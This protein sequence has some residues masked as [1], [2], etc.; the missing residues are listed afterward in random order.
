[1][2]KVSVIIP[3]DNQFVYTVNFVRSILSNTEGVEY[4]VIIADDCST[5]MTER[6]CDYLPGIRLVRTDGNQGFIRNC[7]NAA[8]VANGKYLV[9]LNNDTLVKEEWLSSLVGTMESD[10]SIG[11]AGS[12]LIYPDGRLQEAGCIVWG[13]GTI[14]NYGRGMNPHLPEFNYFKDTDYVSGASFIIS[15]GLWER[16]GGFDEHYLPAYCEDADLS[17]RVRRE[18]LRTVYQ[19]RSEVIHFEGIS[20]GKSTESGLKAYQ[21][22]NMKK[23]YDR[24]KEELD[25]RPPQGVDVF[26]ARDRSFGRTTVVFVDEHTVPYD[27]DA[28]S[29]S[30]GQYM[31]LLSRKG[32]CVKLIPDDFVYDERYARYYEGMGIEV[33]YGSDYRNGWKRWF[34]D[35]R[36][37]IDHVILSR[38][39]IA[40]KYIVFIKKLGIH[41][42]Y[43][44]CDLHYLRL[45]REASVTGSRYL[46]SESERMRR[47]ETRCMQRSDA[48]ITLSSYELPIIEGMV[49]GKGCLVPIYGFDMG[50]RKVRNVVG[51]DLM[52]VGNFLHTPNADAVDWFMTEI[53]PIVKRR[54]PD[55]RMF[56][57]GANPGDGQTGYVSEDVI[58]TGRVSDE[59]LEH[60][61]SSC[62]VCVIPLRYGAGVK[63]KLL[64]AMYNGIPIVSTSVGI[65]GLDGLTD[66]LHPC[67]DPSG[68][69]DEIIRMCT[70]PEYAEGVAEG[71]RRYLENNYSTEA[72]IS[73][74][75]NA[76]GKQVRLG[77]S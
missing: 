2:P 73:A 72:C 42:V 57:V 3:V 62:R 16:L 50:L 52:F 8:K 13:D 25:G 63:G 6:I 22:T 43:N 9:F 36:D 67:D 26:E 64:E 39:L 35:N 58:V 27:Q 59:E 30:I 19:P 66:V 48:V 11:L 56:I 65:E 71:C 4:E 1:M 37:H 32:Y 29:R 55:V 53:F 24:W 76:L 70:D 14:W 38:P 7:N 28:G 17:F 23:F 18:G 12:K 20:N 61:Y 46:L 40:D 69:A 77:R 33:L 47:I 34:R 31:Q 49:P 74:L 15:R 44:I 68:F 10:S 60:L 45:Q 41:A 75:E 54:I 5:D 51:N 21:V